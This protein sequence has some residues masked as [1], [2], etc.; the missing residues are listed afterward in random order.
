MKKKKRRNPSARDEGTPETRARLGPDII[1]MLRVRKTL[2]DAQALVAF[3]IRGIA[4]SLESRFL[5]SNMGGLGD[6]VMSSAKT[7]HPLDGLPRGLKANYLDKY[8][9]WMR[10]MELIYDRGIRQ[11]ELA[12]SIILND[13]STG[14][15]D[16]E[17][18]WR[19]GT[20]KHMLRSSIDK[21]G[22]YSK[23]A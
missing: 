4:E 14:S 1:E 20:A 23:K 21:Y 7:R 12:M 19:K 9:P 18:S 22:T 11:S 6:R 16:K 15:W 17:H 8:I 13:R 10:A 2:T 3:E 5:A